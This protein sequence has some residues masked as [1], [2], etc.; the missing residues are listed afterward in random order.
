MAKLNI[1]KQSID[2]TIT[3]QTKDVVTNVTSAQNKL[4]VTHKDGTSENVSIT[5]SMPNVTT[6]K[7]VGQT[8]NKTITINQ[9]SGTATMNFTVPYFTVDQQGRITS[10]ANRT[11]KITR[12]AYTNYN[13]YNNYSDYYSYGSYSSYDSY[14]NYGSHD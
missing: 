5:T 1:N 8:A 4:T 13:N 12:P 14:S 6:A 11:V 9:G 3:D 7:S 10:V 2:T